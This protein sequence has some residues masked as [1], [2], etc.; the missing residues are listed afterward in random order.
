MRRGCRVRRL[1][2]PKYKV[3]VSDYIR[4]SLPGSE[5]D[6]VGERILFY[7]QNTAQKKKKVVDYAW[8]RFRGDL[9]R[10]RFEKVFVETNLV[11]MLLK[12]RRNWEEEV[13]LHDTVI[14]NTLKIARQ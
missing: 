10:R 14:W 1:C 12:V 4:H 8:Q 6:D 9:R 2:R 3:L 5:E 11:Q 13:F 7:V